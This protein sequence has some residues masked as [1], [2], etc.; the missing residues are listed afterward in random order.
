[1]A[2]KCS[3]FSRRSAWNKY[4]LQMGLN[5]DPEQ[6]PRSALE[7]AFR[8][9]RCRRVSTNFKGGRGMHEICLCNGSSISK[10]SK[11]DR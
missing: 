6:P 1:M 7:E 2:R 11:N 3:S 9:I 4:P 5:G 10:P 8:L